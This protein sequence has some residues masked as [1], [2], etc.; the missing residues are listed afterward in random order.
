MF[1][2][3]S[4]LI[5][6]NSVKL[7]CK[8]NP[9]MLFDLKGSVYHRKVKFEGDETKWWLNSFGQKKGMKCRNFVEINEDFN[10]T[11]V[12]IENTEEIQQV[13]KADAEFLKKWGIMDY[14]FLLV[15]E[16]V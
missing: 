14:S 6:E 9:K 5:M 2:E 12:N 4:I 11:L 16:N 3:V 7:Q 8:K 13:V 10:R 15:I 1:E